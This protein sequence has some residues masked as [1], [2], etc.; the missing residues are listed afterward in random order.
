MR[1]G[2]GT[3]SALRS[4]KVIFRVNSKQ[5]MYTRVLP[6][7]EEHKQ[8]I[9]LNRLEVRVTNGFNYY[10]Q[11]AHVIHNLACFGFHLKC[12]SIPLLF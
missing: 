10:L 12:C 7:V 3:I 6:Y 8:W 9:I 1:L 5:D 11:G 2:C 4:N